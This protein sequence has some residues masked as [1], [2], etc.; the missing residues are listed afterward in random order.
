MV[1]LF[2]TITVDRAKVINMPLKHD[3]I[4]KPPHGVQRNLIW[5]N[6]RYSLPQQQVIDN[7]FTTLNADMISSIS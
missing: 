4:F 3:G 1:V 7:A 5:R 2:P 6:G